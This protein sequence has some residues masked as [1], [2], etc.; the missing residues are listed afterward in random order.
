MGQ[1]DFLYYLIETKNYTPAVKNYTPAVKT[2]LLAV[3]FSN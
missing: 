3:E 1:I 2:P